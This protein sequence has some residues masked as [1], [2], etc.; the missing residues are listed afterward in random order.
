[1]FVISI[2]FVASLF[3]FQVPEKETILFYAFIIGNVLY[4]LLGILLAWIC[5]D[6]RAFCKYLCPVTIFLKPMS[7]FSF[8]RVKCDHDT[9]IHCKKCIEH[10]PMNV[11]MID[12]SRKR[13][14]GTECIL[15][16]KCI[17]ECPM[18][19]L[20]LTFFEREKKS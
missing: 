13:C 17:N 15:C 3:I 1:M 5:K 14:N 7:Y 12:D 20:K 4:Y 6:N 16:A 11:D 9:C 2:T 19:A 18:K 10:C 8:L